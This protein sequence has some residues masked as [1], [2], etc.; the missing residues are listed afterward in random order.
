MLNC[1]SKSI[2]IFNELQKNLR[3]GIIINSL[4]LLWVLFKGGPYLRKYGMSSPINLTSFN[5]YLSCPSLLLFV[6]V[7]FWVFGKC[8]WHNHGLQRRWWDKKLLEWSLLTFPLYFP[9]C[10]EN[11]KTEWLYECVYCFWNS[12]I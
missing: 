6:K 12:I 10:R 7:H 9:W 5:V 4:A 8:Y 3:A 1:T 2:K 11:N